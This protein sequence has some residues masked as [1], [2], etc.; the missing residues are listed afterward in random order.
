MRKFLLVPVLFFLLAA[1]GLG[2]QQ[3]AT[4]DPWQELRFL[5][6]TWEATT[7]GGA[8]QAHSSGEYSFQPELRGHVLTRQSSNTGCK[9]PEDF[10]CL[11][12]DL[13]YVYPNG[14][15]HAWRAI[16][17]DNEG[18]VIHYEVSVPKPGTVLF[19]SDSSQPGPQFRLSYELTGSV[20]A[21]KF[22]VKMPGQPEFASYLE[23]SGKRR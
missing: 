23:W 11:H 18:H 12:S 3:P 13:L 21:G 6:G 17:F 5:I 22:Q 4:A 19:L 20:M 10:D 15:G 16:Y 9:G 2:A 14:D 1:S 8:A 7:N